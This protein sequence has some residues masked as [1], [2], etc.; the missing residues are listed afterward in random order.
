MTLLRPNQR[1]LEAHFWIATHFWTETHR[2]RTSDLEGCNKSLVQLA[3]ALDNVL[4]EE[5]GAPD[6]IVAGAEAMGEAG[7]QP[8][9]AFWVPDDEKE[10]EDGEEEEEELMPVQGE[11]D[12]GGF[13]PVVRKMRKRTE[14]DLDYIPGM[15]VWEIG[16]RVINDA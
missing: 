11:D 13:L 5:T 6:D 16:N 2:L 4:L 7:I 10:E 3:D 12:E 14:Q 1:N 8:V 15:L 9:A